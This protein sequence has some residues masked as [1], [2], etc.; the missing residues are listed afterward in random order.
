MQPSSHHALYK[1]WRIVSQLLT[2]MDG[3]WIMN[4]LWYGVNDLSNSCGSMFLF[5]TEDRLADDL[6]NKCVLLVLL[7]RCFDLTSNHMTY[8][9]F[10]SFNLPLQRC[11][12]IRE[13]MVYWKT[14]YIMWYLSNRCFMERD[15][16]AFIRVYLGCIGRAF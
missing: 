1:K 9:F 3:Y 16:Y 11:L 8:H 5:L 15:V 2:R 4:S 7:I 10:I 13:W 14:R 6:E 12:W